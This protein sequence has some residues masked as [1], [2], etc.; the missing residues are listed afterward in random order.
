ML[1]D[2]MIGNKSRGLEPI[3]L[4]RGAPRDCAS[5]DFNFIGP[6]DRKRI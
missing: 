2:L 5:S 4:V 6:D 3:S 1:R